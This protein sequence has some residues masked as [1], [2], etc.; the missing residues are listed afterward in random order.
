MTIVPYSTK[1]L[2]IHKGYNRR[3]LEYI[4]NSRNYIYNCLEGAVRSSKTVANIYACAMAIEESR[5]VLHA[6]MGY[7]SKAAIRNVF[8]SNG[9]GFLYLPFWQNRLYTKSIGAGIF[10]LL[11]KPA[12]GSD[13]PEKEIIPLAGGEADSESSFRG[14]SFGIA[15]ITE[16]NLLHPNSIIA[17]NE[18][19]YAAHIRR[20]FVDFNPSSPANFLYAFIGRKWLGIKELPLRTDTELPIGYKR[21]LEDGSYTNILQYL[22]CTFSD[23]LSLSKKRIME[24]K[25]AND[26][27]SPEYARNILGLRASGVGKIYTLRDYNVI[28]GQIC[29][30]RYFRYVIVADPGETASETAFI[31]AAI[32]N[33]RIPELHILNEYSHTNAMEGNIANQKT[34]ELYVKDFFTFIREAEEIM[35]MLPSKIICD[36]AASSFIRAYNSLARGNGIVYPLRKSV[37]GEISERIKDGISLQFS[38]RLKY[39]SVG[40]AKTIS[41]FENAE[42]DE[43]KSLKGTYERLDNPH[44]QQLGLVDCTEYA[45]AAFGNFL[46]RK[47]D[48]NPEDKFNNPSVS[49]KDIADTSIIR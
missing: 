28:K 46:F 2:E 37:K 18:R 6:V 41:E 11:L 27:N 34:S 30:S 22:H 26:P 9:L 33:D 45:I 21:K 31:L 29:R 19:T 25:A 16:A 43:K 35:G 15:F 24:I 32:T 12:P 8:E 3:M 7:S 17:L 48:S 13:M 5:D 49:T 14:A 10:S 36:V 38:G 42:Y 44:R 4:A 1:Y 39:H 23:N 20:F 47:V 40:A